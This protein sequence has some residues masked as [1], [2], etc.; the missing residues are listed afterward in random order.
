MPKCSAP[1]LWLP[2]GEGM[3]STSTVSPAGL[4]TSLAPSVNDEMRLTGLRAVRFSQVSFFLN[5]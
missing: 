1:A 2:A 5:E 3:L 4:T